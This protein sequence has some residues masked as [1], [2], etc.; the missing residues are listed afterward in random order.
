[1]SI[2][3]NDSRYFTQR[4]DEKYGDSMKYLI[5]KSIDSVPDSLDCLL[6]VEASDEPTQIDIA[7]PIY[8]CRR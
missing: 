8:I 1:M 4:I 6:D 7:F 3:S 5:K 2:H